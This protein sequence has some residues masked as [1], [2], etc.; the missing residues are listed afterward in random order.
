MKNTL[1]LGM[2]ILGALMVYSGFKNWTLFE[3]V[4]FFT[5]QDDGGAVETAPAGP[6]QTQGETAPERAPAS[7]DEATP[8]G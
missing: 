6:E 7:H 2:I 4:R 5:G 1:A 3:A 8:H